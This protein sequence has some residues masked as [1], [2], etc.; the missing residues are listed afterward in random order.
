[1]K[2]CP[3]R[4]I[5]TIHIYQYT[6]ISRTKDKQTMKFGPLV[7]YDL[8]N[9][10]LGKLHSKCD[11]ETTP[12]PFSKDLKLSVSLYEQSI[13]FYTF[14]FYCMSKISKYIETKV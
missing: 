14:F 8:R 7:E 1:M 5:V 13:K 10:F 6:N 3:W 11:E 4:Q 9:V 2:I 12:G